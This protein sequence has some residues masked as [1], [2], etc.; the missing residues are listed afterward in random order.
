M[1]DMINVDYDKYP[2]FPEVRPQFLPILDDFFETVSKLLE[3]YELSSEEVVWLQIKE[4]PI[5]RLRIYFT[6]EKFSEDV[7][8]EELAVIT[9]V[10]G[11]IEKLVDKYE[12][13]KIDDEEDIWITK[14]N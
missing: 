4:K 13:I 14:K 3:T 6:M 7:E 2:V 1:I 11:M 5:G 12:K 8:D 9:F 10:H